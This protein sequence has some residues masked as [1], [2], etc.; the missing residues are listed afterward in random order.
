MIP[1]YQTILYATNLEASARKAFRHILGIAQRY[2]AKVHVIH[3]IPEIETSHQQYA[4][5]ILGK[6]QFKELTENHNREILAKLKGDLR[7]FADDEQQ[8]HAEYSKTVVSIE[9]LQGHP[10]V[11]ILQR[12]DELNADLLVFGADT[13][14]ESSFLGGVVKRVLRH[15]HRPVLIVPMSE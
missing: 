3:V 11:K 5:A 12:A 1:K 2:D 15:S 9:L 4:A 10:A 8:E 6:E 13:Q 14:Q 7:A